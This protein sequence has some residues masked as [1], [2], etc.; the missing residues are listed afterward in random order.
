MLATGMSQAETA[1]HFNISTR[2]ILTLQARYR[3]GGI[4]ALEPRSKRPHSNPRTPDPSTVDRILE[5]RRTSRR[6][7][8][9]PITMVC[10]DNRVDI[11]IAA[12]G[13]QIAAYTLTEEKIYFNKK[14]NELDPQ[15][16]N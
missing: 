6:W 16:G 7:D 14:D 10:I 8:G 4:K 1:E 3:E 9:K 13:A 11:K 15:W 12:T 5:L 2:W